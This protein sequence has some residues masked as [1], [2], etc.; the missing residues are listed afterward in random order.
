MLNLVN[1]EAQPTRDA[2]AFVKPLDPFFGLFEIARLGGDDQQGIE[3]LDRNVFHD[4]GKRTCRARA[5]DSVQ[6][7]VERFHIGR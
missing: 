2:T 4:A 7:A 6:I 3:S 5:E 1:V